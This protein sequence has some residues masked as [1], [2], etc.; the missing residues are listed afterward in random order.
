MA[1]CALL[2]KLLSDGTEESEQACE[3]QRDACLACSQFL[4]ATCN[5][6]GGVFSSIL[7]DACEKQ[8][9]RPHVFADSRQRLSDLRDSA[10]EAVLDADF[11]PALSTC[12]VIVCCQPKD[13]ERNSES[14][15][16][17]E[18]ELRDSI[19]SLL[20]QQQAEITIHL[21]LPAQASDTADAKL[22][23]LAAGYEAA[24]RNVRV[25]R[26]QYSTSPLRAVHEMATRLRSEFIAL[27][28]AEAISL[29][30]RINVAVMELRRSGL[31]FI[32]SPLLTPEGPMETSNEP[33]SAF[34]E[35]LTWPTLVFRRASFVDLGGV[36]DR[37]GD[38]AIELLYRARASGARIGTLPSATVQTFRPWAHDPIGPTPAYE[39]RY[40][41]LQHHGLGF[42]SEQIACDVVAPIFAQ[43]QYVGPA[44]ESIIEQ[45]SAETIV[46]MI[47]DCG[48]ED[49]TDLFRYWRDHP[50]IRQYRNVRNLGQYTSFN[51]VSEY[52][53]TDLVAVQD[54]DDVSLPHR[55][56][57]SG[58]LLRWCGADYFAGAMEQF[59]A[60]EPLPVR[61]S[62]Y[63]HHKHSP[64]FAMNPTACFQVSMFRSLGG[65][66]DFGS[67]E[68]NRCGFDTEFM[69][70]AY[71]SHRRFA[72]SSAVVTNRR[73]HEQAA[74]QR[75]DTG[76]GSQLR[77]QAIEETRRRRV[78]LRSRR[79]DPRYF[80]G[81]G[82]HRG[83]TERI[84]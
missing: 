10:E 53:E 68:R 71:F 44:I 55:I 17:P 42:R 80:G 26:S 47:D 83:K 32:G 64:Y 50:R 46:H 22:V 24:H 20:S 18:R 31:D 73:V 34:G 4:P 77:N 60:E 16:D 45:D 65:Y 67:H 38:E 52:F 75:S 35:S 40:G 49:T 36:A 66:A 56:S 39:L 54:S 82:N 63:P 59:G 84:N 81:L 33:G 9:A 5:L 41:S 8:L 2:K 6:L 62:R 28:S 74:T 15:S 78:L 12:D 37:N 21:I 1:T 7:S 19:E 27:H 51:N 11:V 72:L 57:W 61:R 69:N 23:E 13:T 14:T 43:L 70:R 30:D 79:A 25:H 3:V 58:N 76:F 29:P 48:P